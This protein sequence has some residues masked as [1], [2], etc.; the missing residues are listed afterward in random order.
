MEDI[1][2]PLEEPDKS[3]ELEKNIL[4]ECG[5]TGYSGSITVTKSW[6]FTKRYDDYSITE[7]GTQTITFHGTF[8]PKKE[9]EGLEGQPIKMF[10]PASVTGTWKHNEDRYCEGSGG[11]GKCQGL[12]YQ[13]YGT[14]T[15]PAE[16]MEGL[17]L[18]TNVW[19][20][21]M[22]EVASQLQQFGFENWYDIATPGESVPTQTRSK[23][24]TETG[25]EWSNSTSTAILT[26]SDLR[27][28]V[29]DINYL[30]GKVSWSSSRGSTGI[31]VTNMPEAE[32]DQKPFDPEKNGAGYTYTII[33]DLKAINPGK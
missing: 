3:Y 9:M 14:G 12:V 7:T 24:E 2:G 31:S 27:Y 33:W 22:K 13:E 10:G 32:G 5:I 18:I 15:I 1:P 4:L 20:T 17:V 26:G 16:T 19:P 29:V 8:K 23:N 25:C 30:K 28:K 11:C 6:D 21:E